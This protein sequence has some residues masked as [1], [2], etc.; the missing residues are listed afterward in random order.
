MLRF[1]HCADLHFDRPFEG[2]HLITDKAKELP[3]ENEQ[4][5]YNI[6]ELAIKES[7]DFLLF[8]GDT[9]H[10]NRPT[11]KTQQQF[12]QQMERLNE[13]NIPVYVIFGNHDFYEKE[14]Y[15]FD[16]PAN[17]HLFKDESVQTATG[18]TK[19][20]ESYAI[21]GFSYL[22]P[23]MKQ[24][25]VGAFP[26]KQAD[27]HL[28]MYH[29]DM[30]S[31]NF[32]PFQIQ[33]MKRKNYDYWALGHI[34]VPTVLSEKAAILYAGT[35]QGH[36][37]KE[38]QTGVK[39]VTV[40]KGSTTWQTKDVSAIQWKKREVSLSGIQRQKA[41]LDNIIASFETSEKALVKLYL[42]NT[43]LLP[44]NWLQDREMLELLDYV[45][46]YLEKHHF[47]QL[48]YQIDIREETTSEKITVSA[49]EELL[50]H[51]LATYQQQDVF[52]ETINELVNYPQAQQALSLD[53]LQ[54]ESF[55][56]MKKELK[57]EFSWRKLDGIKES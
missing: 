15:W 9:F 38:E 56:Q 10:Q 13:E 6:V 25:K 32:A 33:E 55:A 36:T 52:F 49:E 14:R 27:Y 2:L 54:E 44:Q 3:R 37:Q 23:Q 31:E 51:L 57:S 11:L 30:A 28:G 39:L 53:Q 21:S 26:Q 47:Q 43:E 46:D 35:P 18:Y 42:K 34:H 50:E 16:F 4:V 41:V 8:A 17:V 19:D 5:L 40:N 12:F 29:G 48:V 1:I 7:V 22:H 45:N 20:G 24:T